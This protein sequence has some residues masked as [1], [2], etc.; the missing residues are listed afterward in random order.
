MHSMAAAL[1]LIAGLGNGPTTPYEAEVVVEDAVVR[2]GPGKSHFETSRLHRGEKD[3][4]VV[5]RPAV[6]DHGRDRDVAPERVFVPID[7]RQAQI[8][9]A[10]AIAGAV[11]IFLGFL[12][13]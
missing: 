3:K 2:S 1:M 13:K 9:G 4:G 11:L 10:I 7:G 6:V 12:I 5:A 8:G